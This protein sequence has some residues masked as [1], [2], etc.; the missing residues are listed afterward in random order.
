MMLFSDQGTAYSDNFFTL[1]DG[2]IINNFTGKSMGVHIRTIP[3]TNYLVRIEL[4]WHKKVIRWFW[5]TDKEYQRKHN[6]P[7]EAVGSVADTMR[8]LEK[9]IANEKNKAI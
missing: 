8:A 5:K 3:S 6:P 2:R 4:P 1:K 9:D 7:P